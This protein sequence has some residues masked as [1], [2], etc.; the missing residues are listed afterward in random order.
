MKLY[1]DTADND[2]VLA[3]FDKNYKFIDKIVL[4]Q[5]QKKVELIDKYIRNLLNKNNYKIDQIDEYYVNI[6][7]GSF[8]GVRI[9]LVYLRTLALYLQ[10]PIFTIS[11]MQILHNQYPDKAKLEIKSGGN[12]VYSWLANDTFSPEQIKI[13]VNENPNLLNVD[14]DLMINNFAQYIN[15]FKSYDDLMDIEPYYLKM[16]QIGTKKH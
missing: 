9:S 6:G 1:L 8:T 2:F 12:K 16:P 4:S 10:K 3:L 7:P 11:T 14:Y 15:L 5:E 13:E